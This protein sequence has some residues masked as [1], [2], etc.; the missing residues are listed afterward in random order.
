MYIKVQRTPWIPF[1]EQ[2]RYEVQ[3]DIKLFKDKMNDR[4]E[5]NRGVSSVI[6]NMPFLTLPKV[7]IEVQKF[8][9]CV[10][11]ASTQIIDKLYIRM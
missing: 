7:S 9:G 4:I 5:L 3:R 2:C 10:N 11:K 8:I 6:N 1:V